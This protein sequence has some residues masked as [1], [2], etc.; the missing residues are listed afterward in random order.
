MSKEQEYA[1]HVIGLED[2][3][4]PS[5]YLTVH[6]NREG[7]HPLPGFAFKANIISTLCVIHTGVSLLMVTVI[8]ECECLSSVHMWRMWVM[9]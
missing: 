9:D 6:V 3:L 8:N 1:H 4:L 5:P 2:A 7:Q